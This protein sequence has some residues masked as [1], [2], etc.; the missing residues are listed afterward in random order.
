MKLAVNRMTRFWLGV[1]GLEVLVVVVFLAQGADIYTALTIA[2]GLFLGGSF[3]AQTRLAGPW[4]YL[5]EYLR[6]NRKSL[7]PD[8]SAIPGRRDRPPTVRSDE[9]APPE[10]RR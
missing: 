1:F 2:I 3:L 6:G 9:P 4:R 8:P 7:L 10:E 5:R